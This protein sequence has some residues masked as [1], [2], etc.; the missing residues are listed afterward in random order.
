MQL[1][2]E[3]LVQQA[4]V[5]PT[6]KGPHW[7]I[8]Q[9]SSTFWGNVQVMRPID[10]IIEVVD[11]NDKY[12]LR[13]VFEEPDA[14]DRWA[15]FVDDIHR[16]RQ[17][18]AWCPTAA[19]LSLEL[20]LGYQPRPVTNKHHSKESDSDSDSE[21]DGVVRCSVENKCRDRE[22]AGGSSRPS[23]PDRDGPS[24]SRRPPLS[25]ASPIEPHQIRNDE[26]D[27]PTEIAEARSF[28]DKFGWE[29]PDDD[30]ESSEDD[31][32]EVEAKEAECERVFKLFE[33][34]PTCVQ[35]TERLA[36]C[37]EEYG[38]MAISTP[39]SQWTPIEAFKLPQRIR[40]YLADLSVS[41]ACG[42]QSDKGP[43]INL[44]PHC[45]FFATPH[46]EFV[47]DIATMNMWYRPLDLSGQ[48]ELPYQLA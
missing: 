14:D 29:T 15:R 26:N 37:D 13:D 31:D 48:A 43:A 4:V 6:Y 45:W 34:F 30:S 32:E 5:S 20:K 33:D 22:L 38:A 41:N 17:A 8:Q 42:S 21:D 1:F 28:F 46:N 36:S 47:F 25:Q 12:G 7:R 27:R 40:E 44:D 10:E 3:H 16:K 23:R 39:D 11:E 18:K 9:Y 19:D 24:S 35:R 2:K